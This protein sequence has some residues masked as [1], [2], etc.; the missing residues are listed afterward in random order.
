ML[1][2][3]N[4]LMLNVILTSLYYQK[5]TKNSID[6][7]IY[8]RNSSNWQIILSSIF[9]LSSF[10][11]KLY[12]PIFRNEFPGHLCYKCSKKVCHCL[13]SLLYLLIVNLKIET[14]P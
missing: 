5:P 2:F 8:I 14:Q 12:L 7:Q 13:F 1:A 3:K 9:I 6:K 10:I 4:R 11:L